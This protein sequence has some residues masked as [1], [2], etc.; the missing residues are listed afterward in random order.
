MKRIVLAVLGLLVVGVIGLGL[1]YWLVLFEDSPKRPVVDC[2][3]A[4]TAAGTANG[5]L[6]GVWKLKP[7]AA[8]GQALLADVAPAPWVGYRIDENLQAVHQTAVGRTSKLTGQVVVES[9]AVKTATFVVDMTTVTSAKAQRDNRM[10][11]SGLETDQFPTATFTLTQ[12][13]PVRERAICQRVRA[14]GT[15]TLHGQTRPVVVPLTVSESSGSFSVRGGLPITLSDYG[16]S[17]PSIAGFVTVED[18]G[19]LELDLLFTR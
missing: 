18:K 15:L 12:P 19:T 14:S 11:S 8:S 10:R 17:P 1:V 3:A 2:E 16:I 9:Q 5:S 4:G 13:V 6:A 7:A